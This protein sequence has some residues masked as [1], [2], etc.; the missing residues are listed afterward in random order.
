MREEKKEK[1]K[2]VLCFGDSNTWGY[3]CVAGGRFG[4]EERWTGILQRK[5]GAEYKIIEEG[6]CGRTTVFE[7]PLMPGRNGLKYFE[8]ML[9]SHFPVDFVIMMLGT[10][11][12][13]RIFGAGSE[14]SANGVHRLL[15][16]WKEL[17]QSEQQKE[18]PFVVV[19]PIRIHTAKNGN[20]MYGFDAQSEEEA[21]KFARD[22]KMIADR[23]Q[24]LFVDASEI[25]EPSVDD[26]VHLD[27]EG[28]AKLG[29][30]LAE[31]V[32]RYCE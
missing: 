9:C 6:L 14:E 25:V 5:L 17:L 30:C 20:Y 16:R 22:F 18:C 4:E 26:G 13:K 24:C 32:V 15:L 27:Q 3:N 8:P 7:D 11:D 28:H 29:E 23:H 1:M 21:K 10:N 12:M 2:R 31:V 19:S